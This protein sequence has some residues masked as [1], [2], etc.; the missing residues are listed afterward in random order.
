MSVQDGAEAG[1]AVEKS[2]VWLSGN[3]GGKIRK[4]AVGRGMSQKYKQQNKDEFSPGQTL[5][6]LFFLQLLNTNINYF[7]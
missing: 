2:E 6:G 1:K 5:D 7:A 3:D 4:Q